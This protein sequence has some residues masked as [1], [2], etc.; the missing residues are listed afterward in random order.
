MMPV[1]NADLLSDT[2]LTALSVIEA[3][4]FAYTAHQGTLLGAARLEGL[5]SWDV[6]ADIGLLEADAE[7]ARA[8]LEQALLE[9]GLA[10]V[11]SKAAYYY[12]IRPFVTILGR[13]VLLFPMI[14]VIL[15]ST[16]VDPRTGEVSHDRHS[17]R[18]MFEAGELHPL[19]PYAWH[20]S[21]ISGPSD[22]EPVLQR[23]YGQS[24]QPL[25]FQG[26]QAPRLGEEVAR[27]WQQARP[28]NG[29]VDLEAIRAR[30]SNHRRGR[31]LRCAPW[32]VANGLYAEI[33]E[34]V[35]RMAGGH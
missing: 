9:C 25:A 31:L 3:Q 20:T 11:F 21:F 10:F 1:G 8:G 35:R 12:T 7:K 13:R 6:D 15:M 32:Y 26:H 4:G 27:F 28:L 19:R 5:L 33:L 30:A 2:L 18:R 22:P 17:P 29:Q 23:L 14:E 34:R 24:G 16:T